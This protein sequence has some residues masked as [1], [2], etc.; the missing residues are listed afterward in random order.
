[1]TFISKYKERGENLAIPPRVGDL[2]LDLTN[3]SDT[4]IP[5]PPS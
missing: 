2:M 1:M 4:G 3:P 5:V